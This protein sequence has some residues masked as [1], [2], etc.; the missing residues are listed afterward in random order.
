MPGTPAQLPSVTDPRL[1]QIAH[2]GANW[3]CRYCGSNQR[4]A[5]GD[6]ANCGGDRARHQQAAQAAA[7]QPTEEAPS[8]AGSANQDDVV[9]AEFTEVDDKK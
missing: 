4:A 7:H 8:S 5:D 6:C 3:R 2:G 9:D 1:L